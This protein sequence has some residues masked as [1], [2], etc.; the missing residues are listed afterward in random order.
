MKEK[1]VVKD[2][3]IYFQEFVQKG[4]WVKIRSELSTIETLVIRQ[5]CSCL[6]MYT[7]NLV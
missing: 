2:P 6:C 3:L 7:M 4:L 1:Q 5:V